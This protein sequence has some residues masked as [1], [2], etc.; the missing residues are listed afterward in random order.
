MRILK[1]LTAAAAALIIG[2]GS[3]TAGAADFSSYKT[4]VVSFTLLHNRLQGSPD[5]QEGKTVGN[6]EVIGNLI[7]KFTQSDHLALRTVDKYPVDYDETVDIARK[8]LR[9]N[10]RP[11]LQE[12]P[13]VSAYDVVFLGFPNWWGTYP[14]AVAVFLEQA[15]LAGKIVIPFCTHEGSRFGRSLNDLRAALPDSQVVEGYEI[16]GRNVND[17][18]T[19]ADVQKFLEDLKL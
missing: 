17:S 12:I 3:I 2:A 15:D 18:S 5:P 4:A 19:E 6:T 1:N 11:A 13:D 14:M 8:E 9:E 10:Y 16:R 7:A